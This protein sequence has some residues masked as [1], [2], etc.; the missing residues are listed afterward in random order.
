MGLAPF[1]SSRFMLSISEAK[2]LIEDENVS[3]KEVEVIRDTCQG[4]VELA[5]ELIRENK[6]YLQ[7]PP[8]DC[9]TVKSVYDCG[10][11]KE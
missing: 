5:F 9:N 3:D 7:R 4:L 10:D 2:E 8:S 11:V 1:S 6:Q